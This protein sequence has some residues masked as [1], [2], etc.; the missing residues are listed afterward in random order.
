M[1]DQEKIYRCNVCGHIIEVVRAG[2]GQLVCCNQP[3]ELLEEKGQEQEGNEKHVP[4]VEKTEAGYKI[5]VGSVPHPM[6]EK[7]H[8]EW[9]ELHY[10]DKVCRRHLKPEDVPEMEVKTDLPDVLARAYC[11]VHGL[12]KS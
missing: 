3:M 10:G 11:N 12:W 9:I 8:I 7:H 4:V 1:G 5:K 2:V 6:E